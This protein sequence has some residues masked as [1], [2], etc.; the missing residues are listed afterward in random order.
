MTI[1]LTGGSGFIGTMLA[2]KLLQQQHTVIVIDRIAPP[3]THERL[4]F[5][6]CDIAQSPLPYS[7]LDHADAVINLAG[8]TIA[9]KWTPEVKKHILTSR[10][11]STKHVVESIIATASNIRPKVFICASAV[12]YY[13]DTENHSVNEQSPKGK[14]FLSDVVEQW[15]AAARPVTEHGVRLVH[16]RTAPVLGKG[17][18]L[19]PIHRAMQ[20]GIVP[21][22]AGNDGY[23][24]WIHIQD[25]VDAYIF[26]LETST[27]QGVVNAV[28][29]T[30]IHRKQ[31]DSLVA[32]FFKKHFVI[33][34]PKKI[35]VWVFGEELYEEMIKSTYAVPDRLLDKGFVFT[36]PTVEQALHDVAQQYHHE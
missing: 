32:K 1:V 35:A 22:L 11:Q 12:G 28:A 29:P 25:I 15:E 5:I 2:K 24:S 17:G 30:N 27:L 21:S 36:F 9:Q 6:S 13:G 14:G 33:T 16:I 18:L 3:F 8:M 10:T 26:A 31:F 7:V 20:F 19:A 4:Y 34:V 23:F